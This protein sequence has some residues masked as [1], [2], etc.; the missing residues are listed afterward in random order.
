MQPFTIRH[1]NS[2]LWALALAI[3]FILSGLFLIAFFG[4]V[5]TLTCNRVDPNQERCELVE[6]SLLVSNVIKFPQGELQGAKVG[7]ISMDNGSSDQILLLTTKGEVSFS[8]FYTPF[9]VSTQTI[10]SQINAFVN[11]PNRTVLRVW[12]D[13]RWFYY[14]LG[15][16]GI[17]LGFFV[18]LQDLT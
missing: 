7:K 5:T 10:V 15:C 17:I 2:S 11:Y 14:S 6:T 9:Y 13:D 1:R 16:I 12:E 3:T 18:L 8:P 4:R